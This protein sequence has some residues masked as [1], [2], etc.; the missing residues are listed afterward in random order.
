MLC[1]CNSK[2]LFE[3]CCQPFLSGE[4]A[5][6]TAEQLMRSRFSAYATANAEYIL[7]TYSDESQKQQNINDIAD[8]AKNCRW[9]NLVI[10]TPKP[11][12]LDEK[13]NVIEFSAFFIESKKLCVMRE[14][15]RFIKEANQWR[16]HDGLMIENNVFDKTKRNSPCP[17][18][19]GKKFK[20]CCGIYVK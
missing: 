19:Q 11:Q 5:P 8:W 17:C 12:C 7:Q 13:N 9:V 2:K 10:H 6:K 1:P 18:Q 20:Q 14:K 4:V 3:Q 16:Y 15:S